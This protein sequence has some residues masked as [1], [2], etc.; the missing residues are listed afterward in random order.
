MVIIKLLNKQ[1]ISACGEDEN[2]YVTLVRQP[3]EKNY[4]RMILK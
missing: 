4:V 2:E 1:D 3:V